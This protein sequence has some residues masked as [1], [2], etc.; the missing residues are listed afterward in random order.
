MKIC[1]ICEEEF[2]GTGTICEDCEPIEEEDEDIDE[3]VQ[4]KPIDKKEVKVK[5]PTK[6]E[7]EKENKDLKTEIESLQNEIKSIKK[8][9]NTVI[10]AAKE[11]VGPSANGFIE[12]LIASGEKWVISYR[13]NKPRIIQA[14]RDYEASTK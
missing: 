3:E 13:H 12:W 6:T 8:N 10:D 14:L 11:P 5:A 2:E 7:I 9:I 4:E 1:E